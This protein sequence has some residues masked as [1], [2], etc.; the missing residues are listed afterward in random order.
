MDISKILYATTYV[1]DEEETQTFYF[2][3]PKEMLNGKYPEAENMTISIE[4]SLNHPDARY[5]VVQCSPTEDGCEYDWYDVNWPY[6]DIEAL[7]KLA[8]KSIS[9]R[10]KSI[11]YRRLKIEQ[12]EEFNAFPKEYGFGDKQ[13]AE[14]MKKLGLGPTD[15]DKVVGIGAGGFIRKT[16]VRAYKAMIRRHAHQLQEAMQDKDFAVS[17]FKTELINHE[18]TWTGEVEDALFS[19][20]LTLEMVE[21]DPVLKKALKTAIKNITKEK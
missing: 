10:E 16:D 12:Q 7:L 9:Y 14:G 17:A 8:E 11:S 20:G 4:V 21:K 3:A 15:F 19:L 18:Y 6:E 1:D 2:T 13:I 5:A